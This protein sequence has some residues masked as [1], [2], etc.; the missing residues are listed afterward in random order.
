MENAHWGR[1]R[2]KRTAGISACRGEAEAEEIEEGK[3]GRS[4][5][6]KG[7]TLQDIHIRY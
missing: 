1:A 4:P 6:G 2:E 7:K 3:A 5:F